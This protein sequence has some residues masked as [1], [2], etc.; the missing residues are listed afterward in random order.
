MQIKRCQS[1]WTQLFGYMFRT[2]RYDGLLFSFSQP[3]TLSLHMW[4]VF[5]PLDIYY[6]DARGVVLQAHLRVPPFTLHIP[7]VRASYVLETAQRTHYRIGE[8]IDLAS[9]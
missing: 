4:F 9:L 6:L 3:K 8:R 2:K 1:F 5:F 7:G